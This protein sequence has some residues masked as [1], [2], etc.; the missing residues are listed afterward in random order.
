MKL[1]NIAKR[2]LVE[3]R[4]R[5][6][7]GEIEENIDIDFKGENYINVDIKFKYTYD[8]EPPSWDSPGD[9]ELEITDLQIVLPYD[10]DGSKVDKDI[11]N[12]IPENSLE[13]KELYKQLVKLAMKDM[14]TNTY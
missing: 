3:R 7:S 1:S 2:I 10:E 8:Y 14:N 4:E 12:E 9:E 5:H 13:Y 11:T 6:A